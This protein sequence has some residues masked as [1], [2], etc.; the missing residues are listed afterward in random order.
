MYR[1]IRI[2]RAGNEF[3]CK[4]YYEDLTLVRKAIVFATG[5]AGHKD[6]NTAGIFAKELLDKHKDFMVI[7]FNWPA[8]GEDAKKTLSLEDCSTYLETV[9]KELQMVFHIQELYAYATSFG[10]YLVLK[11]ISECDDPFMKIALRCPAVNMYEVLTRNIIKDEEYE[12]IMKSEDVQVGFDRKVIVTKK[13]LQDLQS[14]DICQRDYHKYAQRLLIIHGT[15]D[16]VAPFEADQEFARNNGIMFVPVKGADHRFQGPGQL[17]EV[18]QRVIA[19]V[20]A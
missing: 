14:N 6:N 1:Y 13:L 12:R 11:Y 17:E 8:H 4:L 20:E 19:F 2:N 15:A 7:V 5:F 10:G 16:E 9:I 3:H 18:H